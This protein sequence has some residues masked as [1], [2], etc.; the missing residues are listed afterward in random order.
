MLAY[1]NDKGSPVSAY[2]G[3]WGPFSVIGEGEAPSQINLAPPAER[4]SA[5]STF[6]TKPSDNFGIKQ[7]AAQKAPP[8]QSP[9]ASQTPPAAPIPAST[10]ER[11]EIALAPRS[12]PV[13]ASPGAKP[14]AQQNALVP[15]PN[16]TN[17]QVAPGAPS[18]PKAP[19]ILE[20]ARVVT[21]EQKRRLEF[22]ARLN[23]DCSSQGQ[24]TI[25]VLE[26]PQ[27]GKLAIEYGQGITNFAQRTTSD[28]DVTAKNQTGSLFSTNPIQ[29][30]WGQIQLRSTLFFHLAPHQ[31]I[32]IRSR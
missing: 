25:R 15:P 27:H 18:A 11:K 30:I 16:P 2:P 22:L 21:A 6:G 20:R 29:N 9:T 4:S 13:P 17:P 31:L 24:T 32:T 5:S 8:P 19:Q 7:P 3:Y 12:E 10:P 14:P 26:P 23:P 28:T 1:M